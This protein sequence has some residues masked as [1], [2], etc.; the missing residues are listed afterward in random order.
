[1]RANENVERK[2]AAGENGASTL[3]RFPVRRVLTIVHN[4][5]GNAVL[6]P[7]KEH[8]STKMQRGCDTCSNY[9]TTKDPLHIFSS[10]STWILVVEEIVVKFEA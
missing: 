10:S 7:N 9:E 8:Y 5:E 3:Y 6:R 2:Y 1:M 4:Y